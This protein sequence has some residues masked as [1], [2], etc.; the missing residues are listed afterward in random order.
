MPEVLQ[1]VTK[2]PPRARLTDKVHRVLGMNPSPFTGP[3]T[4]TYLVGMDGAAPLLIDTGIG[5]PVWAELLRQ[6]LAEAK[7]PPLA[8]C[9]M[10][11]GHADRVGGVGEHDNRTDDRASDT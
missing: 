7:A 10:T 2:F 8:R 5:L 1:D 3:G 4:N 11:H 9:L 6:H